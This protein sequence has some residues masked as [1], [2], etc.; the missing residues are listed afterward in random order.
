MLKLV[1]EMRVDD[2]AFGIFGPEDGYGDP[3]GVL[4]GFRAKTES[5]GVEFVEGELESIDL[6]DGRIVGVRAGGR[7]IA[8]ERV[9]CA[10]G[11][12]SRRVGELAGAFVP[13]SPVRQQ[14]VRASLPRPW[15]YEFPVVI[16]PTGVHW[17]SSESN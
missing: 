8:T 14:L 3:V 7:R 16:D 12:Y 10:A 15:S 13:V 11:A 1:P 5:L 17:R 4:G 9:V 6:A 2:L